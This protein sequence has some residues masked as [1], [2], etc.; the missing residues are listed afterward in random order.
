MCVVVCS[1]SRGA[2]VRVIE[3][4]GHGVSMVGVALLDDVHIVEA[5]QEESRGYWANI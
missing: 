1:S 2:A 4:W 5:L 3:A